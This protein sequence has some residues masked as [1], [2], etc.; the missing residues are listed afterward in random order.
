MKLLIINN[1]VSGFREGSI[2]DFIRAFAADG[3]EV[4][5]RSTDGRKEIGGLLHDAHTF[6]LVVASGG[7]GTVAS[8]SYALRNTNI[9]ILPFPAGTANLVALNLSLPLEHHSLS[10]LARNG[11]TL[12][13]DI[14]EL[15]IGGSTFGFA[16]IAGAGYDATI[17]QYAEPAKRILGP[18]AYFGA[19]VTHAIAQKSHFTLSLDGKTIESEGLG[20]LVLNFSKIQFDISVAHDS[21]PRDGAFEVVV[22]K[23]ST[24]FELIPDLI[25]GLLDRGGDY[26]NRS[27]ALEIH[28]ANN[29][30]VVADPPM[31]VQYDGEATKLTTPFKARILE[32]AC[33]FIVS[34]EAL[35]LYQ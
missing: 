20:V 19:A 11:D 5:I 2:Y 23:A 27:D 34:E 35:A 28:R 9:P 16:L 1:L 31:E 4:C 30:E 13:F 25:A 21:S 18:I 32:K 22:L 10:K 6:D 24:A 7:D 14:G 33:R 8:V 26:P 17:M 15:E 3:D 29:V 12:D